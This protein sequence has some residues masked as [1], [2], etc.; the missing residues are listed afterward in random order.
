MTLQVLSSILS[1]LIWRY[2]GKSKLVILF[3][4]PLESSGISLVIR[5]YWNEDNQRQK[6]GNCTMTEMVLVHC[7]MYICICSKTIIRS[8][9]K[10]FTNRFNL[11]WNISFR[12]FIY[13]SMVSWSKLYSSRVRT[14]NKLDSGYLQ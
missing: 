3:D 14:Q 4:F 11:L 1:S 9:T 7:H 8:V 2:H 6:R 13:W 5:K 10:C 12:I